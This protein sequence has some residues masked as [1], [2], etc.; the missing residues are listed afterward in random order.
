MKA[1]VRRTVL[2][3]AKATLALCEKGIISLRKSDS[4][5]PYPPVFIIGPPRSGTTLLYQVLV[6]RYAFGYFSNWMAQFPRSPIAASWLHKLRSR[7]KG[8]PGDYTSEWGTTK[9]PMGP[10][11]TGSFWYR[12]FPNGDQVYVPAGATPKSSLVELRQEV[13]GMSRVFGAS[14]IFKNVYNSMRIAP[15]LEAFPEACFIV[16][17]RNPVE[18]A[19]SLLKGRIRNQSKE[20]WFSVPPREVAEIQRHPYWDQVVEQVYYTEQQIARDEQEFGSERFH[21]VRYENFCEDVHRTLAGIHS[22]FEKRKVKVDIRGEVP[23]RFPVSD[24]SKDDTGDYERIV[25]KVRQ[26]WG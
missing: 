7:T 26:L 6:D 22:F 16:C 21:H 12:W 13:A 5:E 20:R 8:P 11:E 24:G 15:I 23:P 18:N 10:H 25:E 1:V 2:P 3:L 14:M 9:G 17:R 4:G 19:R